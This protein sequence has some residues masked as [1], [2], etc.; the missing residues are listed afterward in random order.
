MHD[1][2]H[3]CNTVWT[4]WG[5]IAMLIYKDKRF[6]LGL[7]WFLIYYLFYS[8]WVMWHAG[9]CIGPRFLVQVYPFLL[10]PLGYFFEKKVFTRKKLIAILF[11]LSYFLSVYVNIQTLR[12]NDKFFFD[13]FQNIYFKK[14]SYIDLK[15]I[16]KVN[17][18]Y[19]SLTNWN[20]KYSPFAYYRYPS[21]GIPKVYKF[22]G[23]E[24]K[25]YTGVIYLSFFMILLLSII[26]AR[27][28][29]NQ[30]N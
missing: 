7:S 2:N 12:F 14:Y 29:K 17:R 10:I 6:Y 8:G 26:L 30:Q 27:E 21:L 28:F 24:K 22:K 15:V 13:H 19:Y 20:W 5:L 23:T 9:I 16:L 4:L 1:F 3:W 25:I 18:I 11:L